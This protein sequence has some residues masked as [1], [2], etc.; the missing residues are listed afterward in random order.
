MKEIC[1]NEEDENVV[2]DKLEAMPREG[3]RRMLRR[4]SKK[5]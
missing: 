1:Q 5:R 2:G 3:A 4:H